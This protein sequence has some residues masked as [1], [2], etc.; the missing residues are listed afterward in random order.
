MFDQL[1]EETTRLAL[2]PTVL[3]CLGELF[4]EV[5]LGFFVGFFVAVV[6]RCKN[7]SAWSARPWQGGEMVGKRGRVTTSG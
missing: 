6:V 3:F 4:L 5:F 7:I 1:V 2:R